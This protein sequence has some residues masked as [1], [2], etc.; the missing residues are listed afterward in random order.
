MHIEPVKNQTLY[1]MILSDG[2]IDVWMLA[3]TLF[4]WMQQYIASAKSFM[5]LHLRLQTL[6]YILSTIHCNNR[7]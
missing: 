6:Q 5:I 7:R 2:S 4:L 3:V 1:V